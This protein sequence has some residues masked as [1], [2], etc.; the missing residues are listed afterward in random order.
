MGRQLARLMGGPAHSTI[1]SHSWMG[2]PIDE[3]AVLTYGLEHPSLRTVLLTQPF[4]PSTVCHMRLRALLAPTLCFIQLN[5]LYWL[6]TIFV[7]H[8]FNSKRSKYYSNGWN[9]LIWQWPQMH[10][11][12]SYGRDLICM[13]STNMVATSCAWN[14]PIWQRPHMHEIYQYGSNLMCMKCTHMAA[15]SCV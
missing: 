12:F 10:E 2:R 5:H 6:G 11:I 14:L 8:N 3:W 4:W 7:C 13:K 15:T 9:I 1:A